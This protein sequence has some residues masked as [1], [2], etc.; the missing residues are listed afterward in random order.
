MPSWVPRLDFA[1][2]RFG[3]AAYLWLLAVPALL[4]VM[5]GWRVWRRRR[6]VKH[7]T[8]GRI[9]PVRERFSLLGDLGFWFFAVRGQ[10][11]P[12]RGAVAPAGGGRR[13]CGRAA[14]TW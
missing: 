14:W 1:T 3:D 2:T 7:F 11:A 8:R 4:V 13:R 9:V 12:D 6:D 5:W 10:R